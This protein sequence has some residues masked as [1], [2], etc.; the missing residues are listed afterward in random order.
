MLST[1]DSHISLYETNS[2]LGR[3]VAL[4]SGK[5]EIPEP[6]YLLA[7]G[8]IGITEKFKTIY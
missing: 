6:D 2:I 3:S 7:Q 1:V 5:S 8:I 4:Y